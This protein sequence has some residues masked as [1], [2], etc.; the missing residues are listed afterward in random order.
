MQNYQNE[1]YAPKFLSTGATRYLLIV[2]D[3]EDSCGATDDSSTLGR[4]GATAEQLGEL[5]AALL[6]DREV[7]T[8][9]IGFGDQADA[10]QLNAIASAGGTSATEYFDAQDQS[11]LEKALNEIV[12]NSVSCVYDIE[13]QEEDEIDMDKVNFY[14][15]DEI[16]K[17]DADCAKGSGW[18]WL[19]D[20]KSKIQFCEEACNKLKNR[21]V[22]DISATFGCPTVLVF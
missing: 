22:K 9:V 16:V 17:L 4:T 13:E 21:K 7:M 20:Q 18:T 2:S 11:Q 5:T 1:S 3:G 15:D 8:Y 12:G 14:F 10:D 6:S 19:N